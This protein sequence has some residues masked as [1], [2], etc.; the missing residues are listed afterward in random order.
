MLDQGDEHIKMPAV[1]PIVRYV[2]NGSRTEFAFP[3]PIFASEDLAVYFGAA[4]R[5]SGFDISGAGET[6]GGNIIFDTAPADGQQI[7]LKRELPIER[8]TDFIEGG[9]FSA[10]TINNELDYMVASMQQIERSDRHVLRYADH[11][12]PSNNTLPNRGE[13]AEK[14]LGFDSNGDPVALKLDS[15]ISSKDYIIGGNG[16]VSREL[17]SK[18]ADYVSIKDFGAIG[19]GVADDTNAIL[20]ALASH[21]AIF[22]PEG[23]YRITATLRLKARQTLFGLGASSVLVCADKS[24]NALEIVEDHVNVRGLRIEGSDIAI[25]L[26]GLTRPVVQTA[27]TDVTIIAPNIGVQLDGY[28]DANKPC[29]WNNFTRVLVEQPAIHGFHLTKSGAGDTPNANKFIACRAY[30]LGAPITGA[31]F[32][33]EYGRYNNSFSEC[34]ANVDGSAQGCFIIGSGA[35]E[36]ILISPYAESFN[37]VPNV[38]LESGSQETV[39]YNLL[40]VSDGA[41][42]WDLSGGAYTAYNA[43]FPYKNTLQRTN[44]IDINTKLHRYDTSYIDTSGEV[45][46]DTSHSVHLISSYGGALTVKLPEPAQAVG[47]VMMIKKTDSSANV[48]TVTEDGGAGPDGRSYFLG[49]ENDYVNV[50][51]NGAEWFVISSNRSPGNTRYHDG[52]GTYDIDMAT[53]TY[54]LSSY[55][56]AMTARLPPANAAEAVGRTVTIKKTDPSSNTITVSEQ[57]GAGPDG[58]AQPLSSQYN[59]ITVVSNGAQWYIVNKF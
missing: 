32:Y 36:T 7:T 16:A 59:A 44:C 3:F 23:R 28:E 47:V 6:A 25:R 45:I 12:E 26:F 18:L 30:S 58:Y 14:V 35:G 57:G 54:L 17:N 19:D 49:V 21:D 1:E 33:I 22:V 48:I 56:G 27:V 53:D 4:K 20:S 46:L 8:I 43:G 50:L 5:E 51:S 24:F 40:S 11:E 10:A 15:T 9:D 34:E 41:A 39:I 55:G 29:Y 13:R 52:S 42:I 38:K 31:G 37:Q 2:G